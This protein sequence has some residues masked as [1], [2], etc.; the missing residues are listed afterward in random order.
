MHANWS[1]S[2]QS[3]S[4][5][6]RGSPYM[7]DVEVAAARDHRVAR[8]VDELA[9]LARRQRSPDLRAGG[10]SSSARRGRVVA[11]GAAWNR[12]DATARTA[13]GVRDGVSAPVA[14]RNGTSSSS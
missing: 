12:T 6:S 10:G 4:R 9:P 5:T 2:P 1:P 11:S 8:E 13:R 7:N 3:T 14:R